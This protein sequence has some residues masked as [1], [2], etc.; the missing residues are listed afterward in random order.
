MFKFRKT[1][2]L[3]LLTTFTDSV[4]ITDVVGQ[5]QGTP[6]SNGQLMACFF[7]CELW[8][9]FNV[10]LEGCVVPADEILMMTVQIQTLF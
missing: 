1:S 5:G 3:M 7:V 2:Y 4:Q 10:V 8:M 6:F 9:N